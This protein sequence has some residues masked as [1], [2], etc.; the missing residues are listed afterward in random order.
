MDPV[1]ADPD[2]EPPSAEPEP[3]REPLPGDPVDHPGMVPSP[4]TTKSPTEIS[5]MIPASLDPIRDRPR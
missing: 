1:S 3:D 4:G 2:E 5:G